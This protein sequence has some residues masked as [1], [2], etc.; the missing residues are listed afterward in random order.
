VF[1]VRALCGPSCSENHCVLHCEQEIV[2]ETQDLGRVH[3]SGGQDANIH[4]DVAGGTRHFYARLPRRNTPRK[5]RVIAP[6]VSTSALEMISKDGYAYVQPLHGPHLPPTLPYICPS[7]PP[8]VLCTTDFQASLLMGALVPC[9]IIALIS[10]GPLFWVWRG[11]RKRVRL[12]HDMREGSNL[13]APPP[14][15]SLPTIR[16]T[17]APRDNKL[18]SHACLIDLKNAYWQIPIHPSIQPFFGA[19]SHH[20]IHYWTCLPFGWTWSPYIFH[21]PSSPSS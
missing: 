13:F 5:G 14:S 11:D 1:S 8:L 21:T 20:G 12:I 15:F 10:V 4:P 19:A 2:S 18:P 3:H 9:L 6:S 7:D 16:S 17:F